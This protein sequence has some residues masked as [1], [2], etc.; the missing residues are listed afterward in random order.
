[1][2]MQI[3]ASRNYFFFGLRR[4]LKTRAVPKNLR[5]RGPNI[6]FAK[7]TRSPAAF[8]PFEN[9]TTLFSLFVQG[10]RESFK[11]TFI[12]YTRMLRIFYSNQTLLTK[13]P[14]SKTSDGV[15]FNTPR[16]FQIESDSAAGFFTPSS[17]ASSSSSPRTPPPPPRP[18]RRPPPAST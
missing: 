17:S 2:I 16:L 5:D 3:T 9:S 12:K 15:L 7:T 18:P 6:S 8:F 10:R 14:S 1:M 4:Q 11:A 13:C